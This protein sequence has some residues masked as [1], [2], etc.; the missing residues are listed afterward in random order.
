MIAIPS[1]WLLRLII[2][3]EYNL[4]TLETDEHN[5]LSES[6]G[7]EICLLEKETIL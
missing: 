4:P 1:E 5:V 6:C 2:G 7:T 3:V